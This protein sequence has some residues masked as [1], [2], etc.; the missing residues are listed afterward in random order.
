MSAKALGVLTGTFGL[1]VVKVVPFELEVAL[2]KNFSVQV[3]LL[4]LTLAF[5]TC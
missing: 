2:P 3:L 1:I 5:P 4:Q